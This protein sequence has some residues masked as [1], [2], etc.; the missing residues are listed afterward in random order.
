MEPLKRCDYVS[1][2]DS[3]FFPFFSNVRRRGAGVGSPNRNLAAENF[4][5]TP[6]YAATQ[7]ERARM[8]GWVDGRRASPFQSRLL[9]RAHKNGGQI[10]HQSGAVEP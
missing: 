6:A 1:P 9:L 3:S 2:S 8:G 4:L 10:L 7:E 5:P